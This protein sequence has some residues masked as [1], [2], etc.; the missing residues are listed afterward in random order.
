VSDHFDYRSDKVGAIMSGA[1]PIHSLRIV[2]HVPAGEGV[3][4]LWRL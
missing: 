3:V 1:S 4:Q 2:R